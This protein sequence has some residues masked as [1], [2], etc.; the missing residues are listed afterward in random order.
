MI[1]KRTKK[2]AALGGV[3]TAVHYVKAVVMPA[4]SIG[5]LTPDRTLAADLTAE[6]VAA[7]KAY[8]AAR[9]DAGTLTFE[10]VVPEKPPEKT[11]PAPKG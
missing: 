1:C 5:A 9:P 6:Q 3:S 2:L 7:V 8:Y 10:P 4:G 11:P